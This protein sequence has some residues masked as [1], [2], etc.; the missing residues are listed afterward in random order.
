MNTE[1]TRYDMLDHTMPDM[2]MGLGVWTH[3]VHLN[4]ALIYRALRRASRD[5]MA[6]D[7]YAEIDRTQEDLKYRLL[8]LQDRREYKRNG[9]WRDHVDPVALP[10]SQCKIVG[11]AAPD[12]ICPHDILL[13]A[14]RYA[15][16]A[17]AGYGVDGRDGSL[18]IYW[19]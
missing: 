14:V 7:P 4:D 10:W 9:R 17:C 19:D 12:P 2:G 5:H 16:H 1:L 13:I 6:T 15:E 8:H 3:L 18:H 11:V